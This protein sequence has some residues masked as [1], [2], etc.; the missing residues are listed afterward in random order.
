M[1]KGLNIFGKVSD[2]MK[3]NYDSRPTNDYVNFLNGYDTTNVDQTLSNLNSWANRASSNLQNMGDYTFRVGGSEFEKQR[4]ED[5]TYENYLNKILPVY[6]SSIDN[7]QTRLLNQGIGVDS[8]AY[9]KALEALLGAQNTALNDAAFDAMKVGQE[10][11]NN[12]LNNQI[13]IA[14]FSNNAQQA[15]IDQLL[16]AIENSKS[17]YDVETD[18]YSALD[19]LAQNKANAQNQSLKHKLNAVKTAANTATKLWKR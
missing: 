11:Y 14:N 5:A 15:Y 9:R 1:S 12:D 13:A 4:M 6:E 16:S 10:A 3:V 7:L 8:A 17:A 19:N 18:K 2:G